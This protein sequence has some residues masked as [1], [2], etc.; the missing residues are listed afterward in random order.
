MQQLE[1]CVL[2]DCWANVDWLNDIDIHSL[3]N[4]RPPDPIQ[5]AEEQAIFGKE[6][7]KGIFSN[8]APAIDSWNDTT[9]LPGIPIIYEWEQVRQTLPSCGA[10]ESISLSLQNDTTLNIISRVETRFQLKY[11][12]RIHIRT[13]SRTCAVPITLFSCRREFLGG[14]MGAIV[15]HYNGLR[16]GILHCDVSE[17]NTWLRVRSFTSDDVVPAWDGENF[18]QRAGVLG[19]WGSAQDLRSPATMQKRQGFVTGTIPFMATELLR[20]DDGFPTPFTLSPE[21]EIPTSDG[22]IPVTNKPAVQ[23]FPGSVRCA[24]DGNRIPVPAWAT[25]EQYPCTFEEVLTWRM[26]AKEDV[27]CDSLSPYF[28][29]GQGGEEFRDGMKRLFQYFDTSRTPKDHITHKIFVDIL[30]QMKDAID[31]ADDIASNEQVMAARLEYESW[32]RRNS[33]QVMVPSASQLKRTSRNT[34]RASTQVTRSSA[35]RQTTASARSSTSARTKRA[36]GHSADADESAK[37]ARS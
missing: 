13:L 20:P 8:C 5:D 16:K 34:S 26:M 9:Y 6:D 30:Q 7:S 15:G 14:F 28:S 33:G 32:S 31:P 3:L 29:N 27:V 24:A 12:P 17:S 18:V 25:T 23:P 37:R 11:E 2:K 35:S 10:D 22:H 36:Y 21:P 1:H 19:D 4:S